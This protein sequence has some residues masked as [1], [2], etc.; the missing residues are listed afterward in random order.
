[1]SPIPSRPE[2]PVASRRRFLQGLAML[3]VGGRT[4]LTSRDARAAVDAVREV[5]RKAVE[6]PEMPRRTLGRTGWEASRLVFGCGAALSRQRRD[7]LLEAAFDAG[8]NVFD[9]GFRGFYRDAEANLAPFLKRRRDS[10]FLISKAF[11]SRDIEPG[12]RLSAATLRQAA[13]TW[14]ER[15]DASLRELGVEQVDA[16]YLMAANNVS[17][18]G[19][20]EL[21]AAFEKAKQAGKARHFGLSTHQNAQAVLET[22]TRSGAYDLAMVAVTRAGTTGRSATCSRARSPWRSSRRCSPGRGRPASD[23]SA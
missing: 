7:D 16:Y 23:S 17:L 1:M 20:D 13:A 6:W 21:R 22:A 9:V 10:V 15:L 5:A 18:V 12:Q 14:S 4:L 11:P 3:A 2:L 8:I 19:S